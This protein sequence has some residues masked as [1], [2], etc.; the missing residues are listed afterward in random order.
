MALDSKR[1]EIVLFGG[2]TELGYFNDIWIYDIDQGEW[3]VVETSGP[4]PAARGAM[5]F[6]YDVKNDNF[7]MFG[8]FS[9]QGFY[10]DTWLFD[11]NTL[12]WTELQPSTS[13]PPIRTRM[14]YDELRGNPIFF[15]GDV[16]PS[17]GHQG[18][19]EPYDKSW[20]FDPSAQNW[21]EIVTSGSPAPRALNGVAYESDS[22]SI[23][24]FGGTDSLI[25]DSNFVGREYQDTW[26][27]R[28]EEAS[29]DGASTAL[30][31]LAVVA[32]GG[33]VAIAMKFRRRSNLD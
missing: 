20:A 24:I 14:I 29:F 8:G 22:G 3:R 28:V 13:P 19:P 5:S 31:I 1:Q 9:N 32:G 12:A 33:A 27:L 23:L 18:S 21:K 10:S 7:V 26:E 4:V 6:V 2:F 16:I 25:D 30:T 15:G 17:E 11:P